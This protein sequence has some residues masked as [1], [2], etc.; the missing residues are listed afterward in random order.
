MF[1]YIS[2]GGCDNQFIRTERCLWTDCRRANTTIDIYMYYTC[3][4]EI[5]YY[6]FNIRIPVQSYWYLLTL[7]LNKPFEFQIHMDICT[8]YRLYLLSHILIFYCL[9]LGELLHRFKKIKWNC[10]REYCILSSG[11]QVKYNIETHVMFSSLFS[12]LFDCL[13]AV[14]YI[15]LEYYPL[16]FLC[17]LCF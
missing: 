2:L 6:F 1:S 7:R 9:E 11:Y 17:L 3:I 8:Q 13:T 10:I 14:T 16:C 5:L 15:L 4:Y 12:S